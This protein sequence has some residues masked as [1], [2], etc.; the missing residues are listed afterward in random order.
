VDRNRIKRRLRECVRESLPLLTS[1]VDVVLH[2]RRS[3]LTTE[4][5]GLE[6]EVATIFRSVQA[7]CDRGKSQGAGPSAKGHGPRAQASEGAADVPKQPQG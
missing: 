7:A 1:D 4:F 5:A 6:R 2:P 3:V